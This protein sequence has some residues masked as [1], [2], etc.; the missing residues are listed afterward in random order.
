MTY[1]KINDQQYPAT[2]VGLTNDRSW[3]GRASKAVTLNMD[4]ETAKATF[5]DDVSWSI[6][7]QED[8]DNA[9]VYDNSEYSAAGPITDNRDG[10]VT[11]KMGKP[12]AEEI[13]DILIGG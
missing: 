6:V 2:V 5:V 10:S 3:G 7:Y 8:E 13:L 1:I 12:T 11:V 4:Y 9:T